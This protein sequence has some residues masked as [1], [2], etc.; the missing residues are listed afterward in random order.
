MIDFMK[1]LLYISFL[2]LL[3]P[4]LAKAQFEQLD[5]E[6]NGP[7]KQIRTKMQIEN[8]PAGISLVYGSSPMSEIISSYEFDQ[9]YRCVASFSS[10]D[11]TSYDT[12]VYAGNS[13]YIKKISEKRPDGE[14]QSIRH[15]NSDGHCVATL[16]LRADTIWR[17]DSTVYNQYGKPSIVYES[18]SFDTPFLLHVAKVCSYDS[19]GLLLRNDFYYPDMQT[20]AHAHNFIYK[21]GQVVRE[22][23]NA[24]GKVSGK[25]TY[26]FD[27]KGRL[28][29]IT[30]K[31]QKIR[32]SDFDAYGNWRRKES[33]MSDSLF[34]INVIT[35]ETREITYYE[36]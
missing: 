35:V 28:I 4:L 33:D 7:V 16:F 10:M 11:L 27:E 20:V 19:T 24:E 21:K 6:A 22:Y 18:K 17:M 2:L 29:K 31:N 1:K 14:I 26:T 8:G 34:P 23:I 36:E 15:F 3:F 13:G 25:E 9:D 32:F 30:S 5:S 12:I